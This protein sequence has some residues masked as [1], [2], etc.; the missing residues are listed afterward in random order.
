MPDVPGPKEVEV[1]S[2]LPVPYVT[3]YTDR[4]PTI[5]PLL[6]T[7]LKAWAVLMI[8]WGSLR[9]VD[10]APVSVWIASSAVA[11][12]VLGVIE[13]RDWLKFKNPRYFPVSLSILMVIWAAIVAFAYYL[14][15]I[16]PH[17]VDPTVSNLQSDLAKARRDRDLAILQRDDALRAK[18][19]TPS[20]APP[21]PPPIAKAVDIEARIDVWKSVEGQMNDFIRIFGE[22][23][24]IVSNWKSD[25]FALQQ[26][27][28]DFRQHLGITRS[29]LD[30]LIG[31]Y[32]DFSDLRAIDRNG[33][34]RLSATIENLLQTVSQLPSDV[35][36]S[37]KQ[38]VIGS[39]IG[40]LRRELEPAKQ[41]ALAIKNLANSSVTELSSREVSK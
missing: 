37:E 20:P 29:R 16:S 18:G 1:S 8:E 6:L 33:L 7:V 32:P 26:K 2:F 15:A 3:Q 38:N 22:G 27:V 13:K 10:H 5:G 17:F 25:Q 40:Q 35:S 39:Y 31:T 28:N 24:N 41:W 19:D 14:D 21:A 36:S 9:F 23:D 12:L 30:Q 11:L 4:T 34:A